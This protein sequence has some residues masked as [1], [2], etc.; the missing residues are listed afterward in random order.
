[1]KDTALGYLAM[2]VLLSI[3]YFGIELFIYTMQTIK[4]IL[5]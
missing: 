5:I 1:M 2:G 3:I 4:D